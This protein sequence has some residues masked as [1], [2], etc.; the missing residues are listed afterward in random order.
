M[1]PRFAAA[2]LLLLVSF[3]AYAQQSPDTDRDGLSDALEQQLLTQF[4]P[5]LMLDP[6]DCST[7]PAQFTPGLAIPTVL[8]DDTTLYGE[9]LPS[10]TGS[11]AHPRVELRFF[12]LW[13]TDCGPHGHPLDAEH[14]AALLEASTA[15]PATATWRALYWYAA[16]HEETAC[17][18]SQIARASTLGAEDHGAADW[19]SSGKHASFLDER[20]CTHGC[21]SDVCARGVAQAPTR[22]VNLGELHHPMNGSVFTASSAWPLAAKMSATNFPAAALARVEALPA[23]DIAWFNPGRHPAQGI[24]AISSS[25]ATAIGH[26]ADDTAAALDTADVHTGSALDSTTRKTGNALGKTGDAL[27]KSAHATARFLH[28]T[29]K[30]DA[31]ASPGAEPPREKTPAP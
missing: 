3:S 7:R 26:S 6:A 24:I 11:A 14:V 16:A 17:D 19:I 29:K 21:G 31:L 9:A 4:A 25:T 27:H 8:A 28:L 20:L 10:A 5:T 15:N 18:V 30:Q 12:H 23:T 13:R 22:I 1:G 2:L